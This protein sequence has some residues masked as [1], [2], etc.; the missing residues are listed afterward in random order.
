[1]VK[2]DRW[3]R[4]MDGWDGSIVKVQ[5]F[6]F[7]VPG[8]EGVGI[9]NQVPLYP[10]PTALLSHPWLTRVS[11]TRGKWGGPTYYMPASSRVYVK[12]AWKKQPNALRKGPYLLLFMRNH[13]RSSQGDYSC[14]CN[15]VLGSGPTTGP[16]PPK[17]RSSPATVTYP[18]R[19]H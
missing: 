9:S 6:W 3:G 14:F 10:P 5:N 19:F 15:Y 8:A 2:M 11:K 13:T 1:M 16:L 12:K 7:E 18:V 17:N 4:T